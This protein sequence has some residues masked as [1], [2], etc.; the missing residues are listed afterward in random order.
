MPRH[1]SQ[2]LW[3]SICTANLAHIS[4]V[5]K[6]TS[7]TQLKYITYINMVAIMQTIF[8]TF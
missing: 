5:H 8:I 7:A 2:D 1:T 6:N 3:H 4:D